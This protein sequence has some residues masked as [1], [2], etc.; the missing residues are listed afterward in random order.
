MKTPTLCLLFVFLAVAAI[1]AQD[2]VVALEED[3]S[4]P[5]LAKIVLVAGEQAGNI[6]HQYWAG[7]VIMAKLLRQTPGVH[8]SVVRGGW[9]KNPAILE[10][11]KS[12]VLYMEGGEGGVIHPLSDPGRLE[13]IE[14][15]I[16]GGAGLATFHKG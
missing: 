11:A 13:I 4:D 1:R 5:K 14:K 6:A 7:T 3:C 2:D 10:N 12:I 8:V 16:A 9:H 15:A